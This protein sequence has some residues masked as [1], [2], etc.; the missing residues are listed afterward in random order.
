MDPNIEEWK[1]ALLEILGKLDL[2]S[3]KRNQILTLLCEYHYVFALEDGELGETYLLQ[4][5]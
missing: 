2:P 1:T 5:V 3:D 4:Y